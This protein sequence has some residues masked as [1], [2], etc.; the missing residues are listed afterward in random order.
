MSVTKT[1]GSPT[2][3]P[4]GST[5]YTIVVTNNG[6]SFVTGATVT[7]IFPAAITSATWTAAYA[8]AGST[9]PA[10]GTGNI[11]TLVNLAAHGTATF[12]VIAA[13]DPNAAGD[14]VNT[15][16]AVNP[17]GTT[18]PNSSNNSA[19]D[20]DTAAPVADLSVT[21]TDG[22]IGYQPGTTT[23]Y[24][25]VVTNNGPSG[26]TGASVTDL[27][28]ANIASA[29][30]TAVYSAG[31]SGPVSGSGSINASVNL[32][33][34]GTATFTLVANIS[35]TATGNL[36]NTASAAV[37]AGATDPIPGNN[38]ATDTDIPV[39]SLTG[40]V[41]QDPNN[42]GVKDPGE[43]GIPNTIVTL[44]GTDFLGNPVSVSAQ[45]DSNG[46]YTFNNVLPS[47]SVGYTITE[48]QPAN[49]LNGKVTPPANNFSGT[50]G[51]GSSVGTTVQWSDSYSRIVIGSGSQLIGSNYNFGEG[52]LSNVVPPGQT[53]R[54]E[55]ALLFCNGTPTQ[56]SINV[57]NPMDLI[58]VSV[59]VTP[60]T[61]TLTMANTTGLTFTSGANGN[62][63]MT[64]RGTANAVNSGLSH[65][66]YMP[67]PY[68]SGQTTLTVTSQDLVDSTGTPTGLPVTSTVSITVTPINHA[69]TVLAPAT[70]G[71][72]MNS[73]I[74]F[75]TANGNAITLGDPDVDPA[76]QL[77][78]LTLQ[79][80]KGT[81]TLATI[82]GLTVT[83]NGTGTVTAT[84][85]INALNAAVNGLLFT[86]TANT[87]GAAYLV[88]TL[89]DMANTVGPAMQSSKTVNISVSQT[90]QAPLVLGPT[91]VTRTGGSVQFAGAN[92]ITVSDADGGTSIEQV[93]LSVASGTLTLG[94]TSGLTFVSGNGTSSITIQGQLAALKNALN[95]LLYTG[96]ATTLTVSV[97]DLYSGTGGPRSASTS[98]AI[99]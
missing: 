96:N 77:E 15:D 16:S 22:N 99:L 86:P 27:L 93:T 17:A 78:K 9:G 73:P 31:S 2:Y 95:G 72:N 29:T 52:I 10:S 18:D 69:P 81:A 30:W 7:D 20:T 13:I 67:A 59:S 92:Q 14:L 87:Y 63:A 68:F 44:T 56:I 62:S 45:T 6:P 1:D 8:G 70:Q 84:G 60:G 34:S 74:V 91:S 57:P 53:L 88:V 35:P 25:I 79:A 71:T 48:S 65:L 19:T 89:N 24:T 32:R 41:Y 37:P 5:T 97:N 85:T 40:L 51:P 46:Q 83:G 42:N 11:D 39:N 43:P 76:V 21:K 26:V 98:I 49:Y 33:A 3:E 80:V 47:N 54:E 90:N 82:A 36:T 23:T 50:I 64:F 66:T 75:S 38:S 94:S 55:T 58:Q 4:G 12:T 61:G 28:T